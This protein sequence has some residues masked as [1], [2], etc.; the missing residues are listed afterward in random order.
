MT[1]THG[2]LFGGIFGFGLAAQWAG[3]KN[4][5]YNDNNHF[6]CE[7]V[8]ARMKDGQ[9]T[10]NVKI[11]E[12][13]IKEIGKLE[14][15]DIISG[16]EPCQPNSLSGIRKGI[17]DER[18]LWPEYFRIIR[19]NESRYVVNE[20]VFGSI[21]NGVLDQKIN[22]LES[23]GYT[24]WPP[25]II[26]ANYM[27]GWH[28]RKRIWLVAYSTIQRRGSILCSNKKSYIKQN[29]TAI[30]LDTQC[31]PFLQFGQS[32][33]EPAIFGV[34]NGIPRRMDIVKRLGGNGNAIMPQIAFK[35]FQ[36]INLI[37]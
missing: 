35:L 33:G 28:I 30:T 34:A 23:I 21:S 17:S 11:Y 16:G 37:N 36:V 14:P 15:V 19:E 4:V 12:K 29:K 26:P 1:L 20:N 10:D 13:D 2:Q 32:M 18:Y 9:I 3:I 22:D 5:W 6:C 7:V 24:C 8:R 31:N 27:G 25:I